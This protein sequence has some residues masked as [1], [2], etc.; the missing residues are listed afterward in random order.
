VLKHKVGASKGPWDLTIQT[1]DFMTLL[2]AIRYDPKVGLVAEARS[3][4]DQPQL[5]N[6]AVLA[7]GSKT[8][9]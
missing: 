6:G 1:S 7:Y 5:V 3:W 8:Y 9:T 4:P 2:G